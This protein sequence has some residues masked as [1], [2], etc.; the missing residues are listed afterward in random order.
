MEKN[1]AQRR[2]VELTRS[3][4]EVW[5]NLCGKSLELKTSENTPFIAK[6]KLARRRGSLAIQEVLVF[7]KNYGNGKFKE[8][9][10]C[11]QSDWGRYYNCL[12]K[13]GQRVGMY[14]KAVDLLGA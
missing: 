4:N 6:G 10:R 9:S 11:Y 5:A 1:T 13:D 12:G 3:F 7:L 2:M 8:C 14:L